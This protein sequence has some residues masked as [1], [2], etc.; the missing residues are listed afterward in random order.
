VLQQGKCGYSHVQQRARSA[1][2]KIHLKLNISILSDV[3][4]NTENDEGYE[5]QTEADIALVSV[6]ATSDG[7][8]KKEHKPAANNALN[9]LKRSFETTTPITTN[10]T[11]IPKPKRTTVTTTVKELVSIAGGMLAQVKQD[12]DVRN[13]V[14]L[15]LLEKL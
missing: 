1:L 10:E 3:V 7:I 8:A 11:A 15:K 9:L 12:S 14:L 4:S 13:Q 2:S 6:L 5:E